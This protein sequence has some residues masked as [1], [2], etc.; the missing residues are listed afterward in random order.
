MAVTLP[1]LCS[2]AARIVVV[3]DGGS[4]LA[5]RLRD[6]GNAVHELSLSI[7]NRDREGMRRAFAP[8]VLVDLTSLTGGEPV[9]M[10]ASAGVASPFPPAGAGV[11]HDALSAVVERGPRRDLVRRTAA[12]EAETPV[13]RQD[14]DVPAG[15]LRWRRAGHG[16]SSVVFRANSRR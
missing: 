8:R 14:A 2:G 5:L 6:M 11:Q 16:T 7:D 4:P 15:R 10:T 13:V 12:P 1:G 9:R 3:G